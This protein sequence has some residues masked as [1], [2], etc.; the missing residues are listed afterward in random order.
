MGRYVSYLIGFLFVIWTAATSLTQVQSHER[1][2]IFRFGRILEHKPEQGLHIGLPWGIDRVEPAPVGRVR[3]ITIGFV[4][5]DDRDDEVIPLGQMLTGDNNLINVQAS[6]NYRVRADEVEKYVVQKDTVDTLVARA[7]ESLVAEWVAGQKVDDVIRQGK[8]RLA[9]F[10]RDRLPERLKAYDLGIDIE[11][12]SVPDI[13]PPKDVKD[14]FDRLGQAQTS[15]RTKENLALQ[16]AA[17]RMNAAESAALKIKREAHSYANDEHIKAMAEATS[18]RS[19][20]QQF[21]EFSRKN[22]DYLNALW[23]DEMT[24]L[25]AK[26][27]EGGRIDLLDHYLTSEGLTITQFPLQPRKK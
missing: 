4:D 22:P 5:R 26:M 18:F 9:L 24:R 19:R 15:I 2:V 27:R 17:S 23:L 13:A 25:Y 16:E 14:A 21:Q 12:A 6:I 8:H 10:L 3:T 20:L 7:A 1:A 11:T